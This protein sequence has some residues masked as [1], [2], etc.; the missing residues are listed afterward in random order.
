MQAKTQEMGWHH[1]QPMLFGAQGGVYSSKGPNLVQVLSP[2]PISIQAI[3]L[4]SSY[5]F[6][7]FLESFVILLVATIS[8]GSHVRMKIRECSAKCRTHPNLYLFKGKRESKKGGTRRD[9]KGGTCRDQDHY[10]PKKVHASDE[11]NTQKVYASDEDN[12]DEVVADPAIDTKASTF[13]A[14]FHTASLV[15]E[16]IH[17]STQAEYTYHP[18][19]EGH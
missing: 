16:A 11:D 17:P 13:I 14:K 19:Y 7:I 4:S 15:S 18:S 8:R 12:T 2:E 10:T 1:S 5:P 9:Q 6:S 3:H